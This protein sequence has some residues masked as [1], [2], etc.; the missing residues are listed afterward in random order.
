MD[1]THHFYFSKVHLRNFLRG[2]L[3]IVILLHSGLALAQKTSKIDSLSTLLEQETNDS[4]KIIHEIELSR[5]IHRK[6]HSE[7]EEYNHAQNAIEL[8]LQLKDTLLYART[9]DNFG[10]L[11]RFHQQYD[12]AL[13]L[14]TKAF[15]LVENKNVKPYYK[16]RFANNAGVASRNHQKYATAVSYYMKALKVAEEEKNLKDISISSNG[17]GN[18]LSYIP[19]REEEALSYFLRALEAEKERKN[20]LGLAMN[21]LS[22]S[23]YYINK[24]NYK[25]SRK[26]L[27][28]LLQLNQK[29]KDEFGLA[30]TYEFMGISY[31]KEGENLEKAV[32]YFQ[33]ALTRFKV[34][35]NN[36][37]QAEILR[38][39]GSLQ[40][41]RGNTAL[42]EDYFQESLSLAKEIQ[43][44]ELVRENSMKLSQILEDEG[45]Y[46]HALYYY[47]QANA[48]ED[49]IQLTNQNVRI[50]M[51]TRKYNLEK[52]ENQIKLLQKDKVLQQNVVES[53]HQQLE[54]RR[55]T[56]VL[57]GVGFLLLLV[58]FLMQ[59]RNY[60][61]KKETNAR[62][63]QEEKE[64]MN[65]IYERNLAQS[66]ILVT[67]LRVNPH[68][69]FNSLNAITYLIQSEQNLKAI[70]Y[71]KIFSRYTRMVL[72]TSKKHVISLQE[73]LK[74]TDYYLMLEK[75]R[76]ED[77][78]E[79]RVSGDDFPEIDGIEIPPLLLQPF[80]EN[81]I[82]HGLLSSKKDDKVL[83]VSID[84]KENSTLIII[85]DNGIGREESTKR[86]HRKKHNSMG[87][88]IIDERIELYN[89]SYPGKISYEIIDK[90][91][92]NG[93]ATGTQ[94]VFT[95][96]KEKE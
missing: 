26:Y 72:E 61:T 23:D 11:H 59:Y 94:V 37:K 3:F 91:D 46:E 47:K 73:E 15:A 51:L 50:E 68:F 48:Y 5:E 36:H 63:Q 69:L 25:I 96:L 38:N 24:N 79:F 9:L 95:L 33:N 93:E 21:Y 62:I 44:N 66:E 83:H 4:L 60:R 43:Q 52:K 45:N 19:G 40:F 76:F 55:L 58:I 87:I 89:K 74:L 81:A 13:N 90:K 29:R 85:D 56:M 92:E 64:K 53:Q 16:M 8:A 35:N 80:M 84:S 71:L 18:A 12:E 41:K 42:A 82:W 6:Q 88:Q 31:L 67:R 2:S 70:K 10:L 57:L 39:L 22:I 14:H 20:S 54:R 78:F 34:L 30:I 7:K 65:A 17:I 86:G 77:G 32:V 49:S 75:N 1:S 27:D 28:T